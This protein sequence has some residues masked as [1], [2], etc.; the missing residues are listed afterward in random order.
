MIRFWQDTPTITRTSVKV[1]SAPSLRL[2]EEV[3]MRKIQSQFIFALFVCLSIVL[4]GSSE[5]MLDN[6]STI[7]PVFLEY[8][9]IYNDDDPGIDPCDP[10]CDNDPNT[11]PIV[12]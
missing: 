3:G 6:Q 1:I 7:S 4:V 12:P 11:A 5:A 10:D 9:P 2:V 8:S